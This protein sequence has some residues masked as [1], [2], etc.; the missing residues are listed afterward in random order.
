MKSQELIKEK[1]E[2]ALKL[3]RENIKHLSDCDDLG[4]AIKY[5]ETIRH[6][7][8]P[9]KDRWLFDELSKSQIAILVKILIDLGE[10]ELKDNKL[11]LIGEKQ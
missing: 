11:K 3:I 10:V 1:G 2:K 9:I 5:F 6:S 7:G 4:E 8:V